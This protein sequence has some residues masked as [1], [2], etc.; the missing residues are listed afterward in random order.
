MIAI[1][2]VIA[3]VGLWLNNV[4]IVIGAMLL[5]PLLGPINAAS[6]NA[7]LGRIKELLRA[8]GVILGSIGISIGIA[9][10][11]TLVATQFAIFGLTEQISLRSDV[12]L[13]DLL[14]AILLGVAGGIALI[15]ALPEI[16]VGVAV[17]VALL[18]PSV[19]TGMG[20]ALARPD[21]FSGA[22]VLTI[23]NLVGLQAGA[24]LV[25]RIK[26][27]SP[28]RY[29]QKEKARKY[30][31]YSLTVLLLIFSLLIGLVLLVRLGPA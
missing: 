31:L 5:S 28:R 23:V 15:V 8:E 7:N 26:G 6:V 20:L 16:L 22:L 11:S 19:V 1:A 30:G 24:V 9:Y 17:A 4:A 18:P 2:S 3:L 27:I 13:V 29:Y 21:I 14:V 12:S 10:I 25:L